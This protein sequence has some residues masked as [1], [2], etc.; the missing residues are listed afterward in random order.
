METAFR[1]IFP[2]PRFATREE[3]DEYWLAFA[4][5]TELVQELRIYICNPFILGLPTAIFGEEAKL[6]VLNLT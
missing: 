2:A 1:F 5:A 6:Q 3:A 4:G